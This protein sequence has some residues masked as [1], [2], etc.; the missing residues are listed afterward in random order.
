MRQS[1]VLESGRSMLEDKLL[2][3]RFNRGDRSV[4]HRV[5]E[6]YKDPAEYLTRFLARPH[7]ELGRSVI[8]GVE[9]EGIEVADPPTD[10]KKLENGVGRL[11]VD[12]QTELPIRIEI[13]GTADGAAVRWLMEFK[14]A[15]AV[16]PAAF[17]PNISD[18]YTPIGQ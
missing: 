12:V 9:V 13:E 17:E 8:D 4:L 2:I 18:D 5:Y 16:S 3:L 15:E 10:G 6:E 1:I 14:W 7:K 11:W